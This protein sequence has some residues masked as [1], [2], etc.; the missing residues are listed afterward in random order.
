MDELAD[1]MCNRGC[2]KVKQDRT[3]GHLQQ[4]FSQ[5][6][7]R[8]FSYA[9]HNKSQA[10]TDGYLLASHGGPLLVIEYKRQIAMAEPQLA[11]HFIQLALKPVESIFCQWRQ[12]ALGLLIRGKVR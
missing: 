1:A 10:T 6:E 2:E 9:V 4:I 5:N 8:E 3:R 7:L 11:S 12:P